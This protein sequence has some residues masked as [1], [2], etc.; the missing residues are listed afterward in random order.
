M[1]LHIAISSNKAEVR[2]DEEAKAATH[3]GGEMGSTVCFL[4]LLPQAESSPAHWYLC[5]ESRF[6]KTSIC[7]G[8][9]RGQLNFVLAKVVVTMYHTICGSLTVNISWAGDPPVPCV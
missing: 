7:F 4:D 6:Y 3:G 8:R 2:A 1:A 5:T 9:Q